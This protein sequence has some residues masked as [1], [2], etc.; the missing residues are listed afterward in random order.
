MTIEIKRFSNTFLFLTMLCFLGVFVAYFAMPAMADGIPQDSPMTYSGVLEDGGQAVN[1][2]R[3]FRLTVW[4]DADS[5]EF[6]YLQCSTQESGVE[7][8][9]GHFRVSLSNSCTDAVREHQNLWVEVEVDGQVVGRT[10]MGAVPYAI[11]ADRASG[12]TQTAQDTLVPPGTV[13]AFA[14]PI[15]P[16]G[17]LLADGSVLDREGDFSRLYAAIGTAHG[18]GD[19]AT[20]FNLPDYRGM[21]LRGVDHGAGVDPDSDNRGSAQIGGNEND[22]VGSVQGDTVPEHRHGM[23]HHHGMTHNHSAGSL[24][25]RLNITTGGRM[26]AQSRSATGW[27]SNRRVNGSYSSS[28][29][30]NNHGTR[31]A[32]NTGTFSGNTGGA[33]T[34]NTGWSKDQ[35]G[36][37]RPVN[38]YVN[39]IIKY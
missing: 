37:S 38:A 13:I 17:R 28:F 18:D 35:S 4:N 19:G 3:N 31:V 22:R 34:S 5:T 10:K 21:F 15:V 8:T 25:A 20:T 7:V 6:D 30:T 39:Y 9:N 1:G 14:G 23:S 16:D 26:H 11:E 33:S 27:E 24:V 12:L 32:G 36:E 29:E 2:S